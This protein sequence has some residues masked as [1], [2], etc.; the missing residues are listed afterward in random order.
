[1]QLNSVQRNYPTHEKELLAIICALEKWRYYLL[2]TQFTVYTDHCT[3]EY[4]Q[5]QPSLS[6]RQAQWSEFLTQ[7]DF[8]IKY[9][10][11][12]SNT[13][14]DALSRIPTDDAVPTTPT[15]QVDLE[16]ELLQQIK[17]DYESDEFCLKLQENL[18][19]MKG[20]GARVE[21]DLLYCHG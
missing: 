9:V 8:T 20:N 19:S 2:G 21:N 7:Y 5:N 4:F 16:P 1:M 17:G 14:T 15:L 11:G 3:L 18:E 6:K 10:P 13:V 12:D